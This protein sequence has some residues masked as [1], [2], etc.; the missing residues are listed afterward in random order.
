VPTRTLTINP[1]TLPVGPSI[2]GPLNV[3]NNTEAS[4]VTDRTIAGGL[5]VLG[6]DTTVDVMVQTSPDGTVWRDLGGATWVGGSYSSRVGP[7][8]ADSISTGDIAA[9]VSRVRVLATVGGPSS[10]V[11]AG[12]LTVT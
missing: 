7:L 9:S 6:P 2:I 11:I 10:V 5:N 4:L 8:N 12:T 1:T 3:G